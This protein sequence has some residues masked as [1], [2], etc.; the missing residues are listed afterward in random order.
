MQSTLLLV[1]DL[2]ES[3]QAVDGEDAP[4]PVLP[5][6]KFIHGVKLLII[7]IV[8]GVLIWQSPG[9]TK[10]RNIVTDTKFRRKNELAVSIAKKVRAQR[11]TEI[12]TR[13]LQLKL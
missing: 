11:R 12:F 5:V 4:F 8:H 13:P 3:Q 6:I 7:E 9:T 1:R 10:K 2:R